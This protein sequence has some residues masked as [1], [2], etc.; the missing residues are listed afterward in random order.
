MVQ[1]EKLAINVCKILLDNNIVDNKYSNSSV[2]F[3]RKDVATTIIW[4]IYFKII[5]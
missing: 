2:G 3:F 4:M 5:S 1:L